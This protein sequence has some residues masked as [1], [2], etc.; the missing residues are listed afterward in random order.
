MLLVGDIGGTKTDLAIFSTAGGLHIENQATFRSANYPSLEAIVQEFLADKEAMITRAVFGVAGPVVKGR[1]K[2]T[3]L[4]W[5]LVEETMQQTLNIPI[6]RLLNDLEAI[7]YAVPHLPASELE[8]IN[9][10]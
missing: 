8:V 3:N 2:V 1:S 7:A 6:V 4:P 10:D 5:H 9:G